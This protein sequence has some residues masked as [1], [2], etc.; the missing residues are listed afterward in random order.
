MT[1]GEPTGSGKDGLMAQRRIDGK[2]K[3]FPL[4]D[5]EINYAALEKWS[6]GDVDGV[7]AGRS[8]SHPDPR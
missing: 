3:F 2:K 8:G 4:E 6:K 5:G 1:T 7:Q